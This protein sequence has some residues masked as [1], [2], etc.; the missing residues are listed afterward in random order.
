MTI[1]GS[2]PHEFSYTVNNSIINF[3]S[4]FI[5]DL[6]SLNIDKT[7]FI[8]FLT[9]NSKPTDLSVS[10]ENK[11]IMEVK[12]VRLLG[13]TTD[14]HLSR[15]FHIEEIIPKLNSACFATRSVMPHLSYETVKMLYLTYFHSVM[16]YGIIIWGN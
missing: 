2:D 5:S 12:K 4:W 10:Y 8:E 16:S 3:N 7:Q 14:N 11:H 9:K 15:T 13:S 1:I 6:L